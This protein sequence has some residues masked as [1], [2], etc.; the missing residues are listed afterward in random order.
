MRAPKPTATPLASK[1][2]PREADDAAISEYRNHYWYHWKIDKDDAGPAE[3]YELISQGRLKEGRDAYEQ[4]YR[5]RH[6]NKAVDA[7]IEDCLKQWL[8]LP[9]DGV[10]PVP[11]RVEV[12]PRL[13]LALLLRKGFGDRHRGRDVSDHK[14]FVDRQW[15]EAFRRLA[16]KLKAEVIAKGKTKAY[17]HRIAR[18]QAAK[19]IS[20]RSGLSEAMLLE[21]RLHRQRP[22]K[23]RAQ[24]AK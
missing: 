22:K 1:R 17:A 4:T 19:I 13:L 7:E 21:G 18:D 2:E 8:D 9:A 11:R 6:T 16:T 10:G 12:P 15:M 23:R 5:Q 24:I 3:I 14:I 20:E